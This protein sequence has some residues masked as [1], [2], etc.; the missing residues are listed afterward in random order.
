MHKNAGYEEV[1]TPIILSKKL[2]MC[3][4]HWKNF[5][6]HMYCL[7]IDE[8]EHAI[9]PMN[10]PGGMLIYRERLHSYREFPIRNAEVGLVHRHELSGVLAGLFRVRS[11]HQD[12]AHIFMTPQQIKQEVVGV[13]NL[14]AEIYGKFGL[15]FNLELSTRPEKSIGTDE[16]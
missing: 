9:K 2:W 13:I 14:T 7:N 16:Q 1:K 15:D 12:D 5:K 6:E 10:C 11:F 8:F 4:G 3:S